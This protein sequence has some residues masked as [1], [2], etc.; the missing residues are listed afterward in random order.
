[1]LSLSNISRL[2][3]RNSHCS[4]LCPLFFFFLSC[5]LNNHNMLLVSL[6]CDNAA[7]QGSAAQSVTRSV[8][9]QS[10]VPTAQQSCHSSVDRYIFR[11]PSGLCSPVKSRC[12][13]ILC[14]SRSCGWICG[15]V[16]LIRRIGVHSLSQV[17]STVLVFFFLLDT[18][19]LIC[20]DQL[21]CL[22][23]IC[24]NSTVLSFQVALM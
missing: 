15:C 9:S 13:K 11:I 6:V 2:H 14:A 8:Q 20:C 3:Q 18:V 1:M 16:Q 23:S 12:D 7:P 10:N 5:G 22:F 24:S 21:C 19:Q 17:L 4:R